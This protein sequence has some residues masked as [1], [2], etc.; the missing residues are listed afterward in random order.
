MAT[1]TTVRCR[2]DARCRQCTGKR[3]L[4]TIWS[5]FD[6][7]RMSHLCNSTVAGPTGGGAMH[8]QANRNTP[9]SFNPLLDLLRSEHGPRTPELKS[10]N[11]CHVPFFALSPPFLQAI[12]A[13]PLRISTHNLG[14]KASNVCTI[15]NFSSTKEP[16]ILKANYSN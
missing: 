3:L 5:S 4:H 10:I 12:L 14:H 2:R 16:G 15:V 6:K 7:D 9:L 13:A 11:V 1:G 8:W